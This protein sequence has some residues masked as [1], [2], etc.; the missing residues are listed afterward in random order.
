MLDIPAIALTDSHCHLDFSEFEDKLPE[1]IES[2]V[3]QNIKRIIVPSIGKSNWQKV[4]E[5]TQYCTDNFTV[6]P[7]LGIHPWF[8]DNVDEATITELDGFITKHRHNIIA[9]GEAGIDGS[10]AFEKN[11]LALQIQIFE[12]QIELAN[13]HK[14]PIIVH[15]RRSYPEVYQ[16]LKQTNVAKGGIIHAFSGSY[17]Q[18]K[19]YIDLGFKLGIGGTITYE[20]AS[21]TINTVKKLPVDALVLETDAPAM[22]L[23]G[24]QGEPNHPCRI[25][26]VLETLSEIRGESTE[27]LA[28]QTEKNINQL[29]FS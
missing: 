27:Y 25:T 3:N 4:L 23:S 8:L 15:H 14:L 21:K 12:Q 17:Q 1:T 11:N 9:L 10:I 20:R 16:A 5:L 6:F 24:F 26:N 13:R 19:H 22:P 29:F 7:C 28:E 2:C 18:A